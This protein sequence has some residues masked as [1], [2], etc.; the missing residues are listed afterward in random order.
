MSDM[1]GHHSLGSLG[2]FSC[3]ATMKISSLFC[4]RPSDLEWS[5]FRAVS[6][7]PGTLPE[8]FLTKLK[9][10]LFGRVGVGSAAE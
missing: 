7:H 3:S 10:L 6:I 5:S 8:T 2:S 4:G 9:N 1:Q